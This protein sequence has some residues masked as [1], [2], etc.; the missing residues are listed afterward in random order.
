MTRG[1]GGRNGTGRIRGIQYE[2]HDNRIET[3]KGKGGEND[4]ND[5]LE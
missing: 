2:R 5:G 1:M 4:E 3:K